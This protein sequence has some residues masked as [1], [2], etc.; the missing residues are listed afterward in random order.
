MEQQIFTVTEL[1]NRIKGLFELDPMLQKVCIKGELSNYKVYPSGHHYFTMK[2][3]EGSI[4]CV[5]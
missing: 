3:A 2:D 5:M 1:N 4:R